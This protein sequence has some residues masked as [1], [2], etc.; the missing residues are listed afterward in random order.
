MGT[1]ESKGEAGGGLGDSA[2]LGTAALRG[3]VTCCTE[4][5]RDLLH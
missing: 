3:S 1:Q 2:V 4:R 5:E